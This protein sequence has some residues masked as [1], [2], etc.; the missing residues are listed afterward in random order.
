MA[1]RAMVWKRAMVR[2]ARAMVM[3]TRVAG[4]EEGGGVKEGDEEE[5]GD[6]DSNVGGR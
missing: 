3:A 6:G 1:K 5:E 2:V 4:D